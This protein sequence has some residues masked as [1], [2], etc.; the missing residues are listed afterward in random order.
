MKFTDK[1]MREISEVRERLEAFKNK[2]QPYPEESEQATCP[3]GT[4]AVQLE[5]SRHQWD[6]VQQLKDE[7]TGWREKHAEV[8]LAINKAKKKQGG[9]SPYA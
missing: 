6:V 2:V 1:Q 7:V 8:L 5:W 4:L 3:G 9:E